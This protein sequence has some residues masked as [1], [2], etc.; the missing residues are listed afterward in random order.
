M[1][2]GDSADGMCVIECCGANL[3]ACHEL[4]LLPLVNIDIVAPQTQVTTKEDR[5]TAYPLCIY[6]S[7][8]LP[9]FA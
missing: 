3:N 4:S 2:T 5:R 7:N 6:S 8:G 1:R 9:D